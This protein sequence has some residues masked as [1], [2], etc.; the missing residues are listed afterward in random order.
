MNLYFISLFSPRKVLVD[1]AV[2]PCEKV[3]FVDPLRRVKLRKLFL[4]AF[5]DY[6]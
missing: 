2:L 4:F 1:G 3:S 6:N 5:S